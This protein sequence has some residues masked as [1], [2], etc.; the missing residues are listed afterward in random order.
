MKSDFY[1]TWYNYN[2]KYQGSM[3]NV[4]AFQK[5]MIRS[6]EENE[7]FSGGS[8]VYSLW[9]YLVRTHQPKIKRANGL[10]LT[11]QAADLRSEKF[12]KRTPPY[13]A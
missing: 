11:A 3:C 2:Y 13:M 7:S 8:N 1:V 5:C 9:H 6:G 4:H 12:R 10:D